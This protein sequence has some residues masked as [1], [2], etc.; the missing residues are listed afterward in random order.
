[1]RILVEE[2][3]V[4]PYYALFIDKCIDPRFGL[5]AKEQH[6]KHRWLLEAVEESVYFPFGVKVV[7][8]DYASDQVVLI[9]KKTQFISRIGQLSSASLDLVS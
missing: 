4:I 3:Y 6:T 8:R 7:Y 5:F 1:M 9:E 2:A